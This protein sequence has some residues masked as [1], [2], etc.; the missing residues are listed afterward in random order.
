MRPLKAIRV[1]CLECQGGRKAVRNCEVAE[2]ALFAFR[3][4]R[5]PKRKGIGRPGGN[6]ALNC[7]V[8]L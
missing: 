7:A 8:R 3:F 6:P 4:G 5:N 2:C 1:K